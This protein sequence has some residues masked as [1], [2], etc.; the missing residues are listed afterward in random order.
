MILD[1]VTRA[2]ALIAVL[3][4]AV[5]Y[6]TYFFCAVVMR[7]ALT[8]VDDR[9][10]VEV[11]GR[12]HRYGDRRMSTPGV[13]G[14]VATTATLVLAAVAGQWVRV[15]AAGAALILLLVWLVLYVRVS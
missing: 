11:M 7:P 9:A 3:G 14:I 1:I 10:L 13:L 15:I 6:G 2:A 4:T 8:S 5:V 12:V